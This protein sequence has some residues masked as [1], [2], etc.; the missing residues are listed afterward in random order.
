MENGNRRLRLIKFDPEDFSQGVAL[1]KD[2]GHTSDETALISAALSLYFQWPE[3]RSSVLRDKKIDQMSSC[4]LEYDSDERE[5]EELW[6]IP[7]NISSTATFRE[8]DK[9]QIIFEV[10]NTAYSF[11]SLVLWSACGDSS[12]RIQLVICIPNTIAIQKSR[13]LGRHLINENDRSLIPTFVFR[14]D[15]K[16]REAILDL[17][18]IGSQ[19]LLIKQHIEPGSNGYLEFEGHKIYC[20]CPR[21]N[22]DGSIL[23]LNF[24]SQQELGAYFDVYRKIAYPGLLPRSTASPDETIS[25]YEASGF[26]SKF[27]KELVK[28]VYQKWLLLIKES[29]KKISVPAH[30]N[31]A[32]YVVVDRATNK[33]TGASSLVLGFQNGSRPVWVKHQLCSIA[34][35]KYLPLTKTVYLWRTEYLCGLP[36]DLDV[37]VW[38]D[39]NSRWIERLWIKFSRYINQ[40]NTVRSV[41]IRILDLSKEKNLEQPKYETIHYDIG[42]ESRNVTVSSKVISGI[43]PDT[44]NTSGLLN[45]SI[46]LSTEPDDQVAVLDAVKTLC[47]TSAQTNSNLVFRVSFPTGK[48]PESVKSLPVHPSNRFCFFEKKYLPTLRSSLEHSLAVIEK[49][50]AIR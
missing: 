2:D 30:Q 24:K 38:F 49:K 1:G 40:P 48:T 22:S 3:Y 11:E 18:E 7:D 19:S 35:P 31:T 26:F 16:G 45:H 13:R 32:D 37:A 21:K 36:E 41:D 5:P 43:G 47:S 25:A 29:W 8:G 4:E 39:G 20:T 15:P 23:V 50:N 12:S 34:E 17:I 28:D 46:S 10:F 33:V 27:S 9:I 44:L 14:P 42:S 6:I